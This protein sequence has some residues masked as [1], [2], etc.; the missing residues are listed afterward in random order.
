RE[1]GA[2]TLRFG[3]DDVTFA[4]V[5]L[6]PAKTRD[7]NLALPFYRDGVRSI[8]F[9]DNVEPRELDALITALIGV[10]GQ[11]NEDDDDLVTLLWE[12]QLRHIDVDYVP[13]EG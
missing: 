8:T 1:H 9:T 2:F 5:S 7:D 11:R 10:T 12:A 13:S 3:S 4:G 6:Y